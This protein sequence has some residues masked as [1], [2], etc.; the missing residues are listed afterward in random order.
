MNSGAQTTESPVEGRSI[1]VSLFRE[2]L[3]IKFNRLLDRIT[4]NIE[5]PKDLVLLDSIRPLFSLVIDVKEL[6]KRNVTILWLRSDLLDKYE[7]VEVEN[8]IFLVTPSLRVIK[9]VGRF[10]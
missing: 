5:Q 2:H 6:K 8:L 3:Q 7:D 10:L 9:A 4:K 1:D